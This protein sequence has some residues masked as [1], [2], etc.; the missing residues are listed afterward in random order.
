MRD[1]HFR[2]SIG[3]AVDVTRAKRGTL[4]TSVLAAASAHARIPKVDFLR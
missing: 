1:D 2:S 4:A 3:Y